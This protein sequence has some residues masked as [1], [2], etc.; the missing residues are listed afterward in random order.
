M[1]GNGSA[2]D[3]SPEPT[4]NTDWTVTRQRLHG[5]DLTAG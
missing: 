3:W 1:L 2:S 5:L 4:P